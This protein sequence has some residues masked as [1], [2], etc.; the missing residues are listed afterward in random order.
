ML[1]QARTKLKASKRHRS[2]QNETN[3]YEEMDQN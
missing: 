3:E 2:N 1:N